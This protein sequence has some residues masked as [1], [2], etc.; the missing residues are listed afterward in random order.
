MS[1]SLR[2][3]EWVVNQQFGKVVEWSKRDRC[4]VGSVPA[5]SINGV[6]GK[7][8]NSVL[9]ML[10]QLEQTWEPNIYQV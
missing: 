8:R 7:D 3:V 10:C 4:Y 6:R 9:A 2:Q 1:Y 5:L